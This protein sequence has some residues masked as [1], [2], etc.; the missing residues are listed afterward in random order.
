VK[1]WKA[2]AMNRVAMQPAAA[3][4]VVLTATAAATLE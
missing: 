2:M 1:Y 3:P 4:M